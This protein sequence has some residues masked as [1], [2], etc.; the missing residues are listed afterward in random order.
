MRAVVSPL[1]VV[2]AA[3]TA[4]LLL[5]GCS[6]LEGTGDKGYVTAGGTVTELDPGDREKAISH[7]GDD[8][9][10][11]ARSLE[12]LRGQVVVINVWGNWCGECHAEADDVVGAANETI[13]DD[14]AFIGINVRDASRETA[15]AYER[16]YDVPFPSFWSPDSEALLAFNGALPIYATPSTMVLDRKGRVAASVIGVL[17]SEQT[18]VSII[19][20]VVA[21]DE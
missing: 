4:A 17:P 3:L 13:G 21:E 10:G 18:L 1:R 2:A 14:V 5:T 9:Q 12:D 6:G 19:E 20:K 8:L 15:M 16:Q 7:A 11:E